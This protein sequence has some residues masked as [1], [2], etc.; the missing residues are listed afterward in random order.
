M[1]TTI[2]M[3]LAAG[4]AAIA[5]AD[6]RITEWMYDGTGGEFMEFTNVGASP[7]DLTG[8]SYDDDSRTPGTVSLS[9]FGVVA[10]GESVILTEVSADAFRT[11]WSLGSFVKVIGGNTVNI[12]RNDEINIYDASN[13]L[14]DRL[15]YGDSTFAPGSIRT[16]GTSGN[17]FLADLGTND[18]YAWFFSAPGD[19]FNSYFSNAGTFGN[20]GFYYIPAPSA[21]ALAGLATLA[22]GR[23]RR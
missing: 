6:I 11:N 4:M 16:Q 23:R 14:V 22:A 18:V 17:A 20:P 15:T 8:W 5:N 21:L 7:I 9:S 13:N 1:K 12:G 19:L 10:P 3:V 2:T